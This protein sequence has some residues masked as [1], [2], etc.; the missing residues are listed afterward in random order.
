MGVELCKI[1]Y[2]IPPCQTVSNA[3]FT[4]RSAMS[5]LCLLAFAV[6]IDSKR[7]A[8]AV[9]VPRLGLK[10]RWCSLFYNV[11]QSVI[12]YFFKEFAMNFKEWYWS[13]T[14]SLHWIR[15][16]TKPSTN[17]KMLPV[18]KKT[19]SLKHFCYLNSWKL[20]L[21]GTRWGDEGNDY[22]YVFARVRGVSVCKSESMKVVR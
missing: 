22:M 21:W 9:W 1:L 14:T 5:I 11:H 19:Q 6:A 4:S 13:L 7:I 3:G 16:Y 17:V 2:F 18:P 15:F 10:P 12:N 20:K 8:R